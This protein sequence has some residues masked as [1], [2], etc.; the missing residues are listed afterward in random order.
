MDASVSL[1]GRRS[2]ASEW[3]MARSELGTTDSLSSSACP[4]RLCV[5]SHVKSIYNALSLFICHAIDNELSKA[6]SLQI[7]KILKGMLENLRASPFK[8]RKSFLNLK[9]MQSTK[10]MMPWIKELLSAISL[11][12]ELDDTDRVRVL[13]ACDPVQT[14]ISLPVASDA[15]D[16]IIDILNG[17]TEMKK[18]TFQFPKLNRLFSGSVLASGEELPFGIVSAS[19]YL[20]NFVLYVVSILFM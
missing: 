18:S 6:E 3:R 14:S 4:V 2:G 16:E 5:D 10:K 1:P 7:L 12:G 8:S 11:K 13:L 19:K 17:V 20:L 9:G 15:V